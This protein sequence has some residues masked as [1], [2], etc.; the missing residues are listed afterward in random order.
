MKR[1]TF[2]AIAC[3][4][5]VSTMASWDGTSATTWTN[6]DGTEGNPYLI[7]NE[8]Q[9]AYLAQQVNGG[10]TFSGKYFK[11]TADLDLGG[12]QNT[13]GSWSTASK[14]WVPIGN[15]TKNFSGTYNGD[16]HVI[17]NMYYNDN[18]KQ[19]VGLF[20]SINNG[21]LKN[22]TLAS[23]F[24][25]GYQYSSGI[26]GSAKGSSE[27]RYCA[28]NATVYGKM[29]RNGGVVAYI[30]GNTI[31]DNCINYG[32][33]SAFNFS[34]GVVGFCNT[35][36]T[37][38]SNNINVGQVFSMRCTSGCLYGYNKGFGGPTKNNYYDKQMNHTEGWTSVT[39]IIETNTDIDGKI[40]GKPTSEMIGNGLK[41]RFGI[42]SIYWKYAE[43]F[44]PRL[45]NS[46]D[47]DA[48]ILAATPII[49]ANEEDVDNVK[50][51]FTALPNGEI[52]WNATHN[53][54]VSIDNGIGKVNATG[55]AQLIAK[56]DTYIKIVMLRSNNGGSY[57]TLTIDNYED[58]VAFRNAVNNYGTYKSCS[59]YNGF[60][61]INFKLNADIDLKGTKNGDNW[62]GTE[63]E[64]IGIHNSFKGNFDGNGHKISNTYV[65]QPNCAIVG[66]LFGC[67][68]YGSV[69]N[70]NITS[71][72]ICS[73]VQHAGGL[74]GASF[75]ENI[76]NVTTNCTI[77]TTK[78]YVA[79]II[80]YDKGFSSFTNCTSN[81]DLTGVQ[82]L[83]GII[84]KSD[85]GSSII[86]CTN[87][88]TITTNASGKWVGGIIGC[89]NLW[90]IIDNC[91]NYGNITCACNAGG[92][93]GTNT[94]NAKITNCNNYGTIKTTG[95][96]D[97]SKVGGIIGES[98]K[99]NVEN[100]N[101]FGEI[102][103]IGAKGFPVGGIIGLST[104]DT[105]QFCI[106]NDS[107]ESSFKLAG[108]IIGSAKSSII[109]S[110]INIGFV[111]GTDSIGGI[112]GKLISNSYIS[113]SFN[114]GYI[115]GKMDYTNVG[116]IC[117][118]LDSKSKCDSCLNVANVTPKTTNKRGAI[119]GHNYGSINNCFSD[120]QMLNSDKISNINT[121]TNSEALCTNEMI[122]NKLS[123]K[124][125][126]ENWSYNDNLY[127]IPSGLANSKIAIVSALPVILYSNEDNTIF[128][129]SDNVTANFNVGISNNA[130]WECDNN[131][132]AFVGTNA[133]IE[134][135][136]EKDTIANLTVKIMDYSKTISLTLKKATG[137]TPTINWE[138]NL[139][140]IT[141]GDPITAEML[142]A[143]V[144]SGIDGEFVYN[145]NVGDI[146]DAGHNKL[147]ATFIPEN[148]TQYLT[149]NT[150]VF[151]T[152]NKANPIIDWE[153]PMPITFGEELTEVQLN[154]TV[155][156]NGKLIYSSPIGSVLNAGTQELK[157]TFI[158]TDN[159][160]NTAEKSTFIEV[161]KATPNIVWATPTA[162]TFGEAITTQLNA[163]S[164]IDGTI[165]Y[166]AKAGDILNAGENLLIA[167]LAPNSANYK[168]VS[169]T[170]TLVVNK[171][172]PAI[173]WA[174]PSDIVYGTYL[175]ETQ[176]NA[177]ANTEGS[178]TYSVASDSLLEG[179][180]HT[181]YAEFTS[182][183]SNYSNTTASV[184][185][186]VTPATPVIIWNNPSDIEYGTKLDNTILN[187][188]VDGNID[189]ELIYVPSIGQVLEPGDNQE[190]AVTF[191]PSNLNNYSIVKA[192]VNINVLP[193]TTISWNPSTIVYGTKAGTIFNA[194][195]IV[196]GSFSYSIDKDSILNAGE[197]EI[198]VTFTPT[199]S[200]YKSSQKTVTVIVEKA[201]PVII[202]EPQD[203]TYGTKA[204]ATYNA[205]ANAQG[206]FSYSMSRDSILDAG[207]HEITASFTPS[208]SSYGNY[209]TAKKTA[210]IT[211]NKAE[212]EISWEPQDIVFGSKAELIQNA[213][214]NN[215][216]EFAYSIKKD[217]ILN[218]GEYSITTTFTPSTG[219]YNPAEMTIG[220]KV[221]KAIPAISWTT[222][223]TIVY[224]TKLDIFNAT[225]NV[226]GKFAY[227]VE[228]DSI[229][230]VGDNE[231]TAGFTPASS[232]F[233]SVSS[234]VTINVKKALAISCD[235]TLTLT[236]GNGFNAK[237]LNASANIDGEFFYSIANDSILPA[238][239]FELVVSFKSTDLQSVSSTVTVNV[240]KAKLFASVSSTTI[241]VGESIP[242]FAINYKG[243]VNGDDESAIDTL[244]TVSCNAN[245]KVAGTYD[246]VISG[247][248]ASNYEFVYENAELTIEKDNLI[249]DNE[250]FI[251]IYPNPT[252]DAFYVNASDDITE[253]RI[254]N[255]VGKLIMI[256]PIEGSTRIDISEQPA[257][258]YIVKAGNKVA[259]IIKK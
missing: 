257:G 174:T 133:Y 194:E 65:N 104:L 150:S 39:N 116:G 11:Q 168:S 152:V 53:G 61:G 2:L 37:T 102:I 189:G 63:W 90:V 185:I 139:E 112:S 19:Y 217:T 153:D 54:S 47:K 91:S 123:E 100:C 240:N 10:Q 213:T 159:N 15:G 190:L 56:K 204:E 21:H 68:S 188:E 125:G 122:G 198:T 160:Y 96:G 82:Y 4:F 205:K 72:Y 214:A 17:S 202:W 43:G 42:D 89:N 154:A 239:R 147:T 155:N 209:N 77:E 229:L 75:M 222:P 165:T 103:N 45:K 92:I 191:I 94:T 192:S 244:P 18:T 3:L 195:T 230:N 117:G 36:N 146:L 114:A 243:F 35:T 183:N 29:E 200:E 238:G 246:I 130:K 137:I 233:A 203:I 199:S 49:L 136:T 109:K 7:E 228:P 135:S 144:E 83:G 207:E 32:L 70:I 197:H 166:N 196:D 86:N 250:A 163:V 12:V 26:C 87:N 187:A 71:G 69:S 20:G 59:N 22:I 171:A 157:V 23:G 162:I 6:G 216:G 140:A 9:L 148:S 132:V 107:I 13:D 141:Y 84:A 241:K 8:S 118:S 76:N 161:Y 66:G 237:D 60:K 127:P 242:D 218:V 105:L 186:K 164:A 219:N 252:T 254:F 249:V 245:N 27:I 158:P 24:I 151:L 180:I 184:S 113:N 41:E 227:S 212:T 210:T 73:N 38:V 156:A 255:A 25:Y 124:L 111:T 224:G 44:Y 215:E 64:P 62:S 16:C 221:E 81:S 175:N 220:F 223:D 58:L 256:Q 231:I 67:L 179:G 97:N 149:A 74:A 173:T 211:V 182:E 226:D 128:D 88:G 30:D 170:V 108:G 129:Y 206:S 106:N 78:N 169:S 51:D 232:N 80:S 248:Y 167:T 110:C 172:E 48:M 178:F 177:S 98:S 101:N 57:P 235:S 247:G 79:G 234:T 14:K 40:E 142:N 31:V 55:S 253:V 120:K 138:D 181:I 131:T 33:V 259:R 126:T 34:G 143:T 46:A 134:P 208:L 1:F 258:T 95:S 119:A 251:N 145:V 85:I 225:A 50:S 176:L 193:T 5:A 93:I 52:S 28:N 121:A 99:A 115:K 236:Y 201:D